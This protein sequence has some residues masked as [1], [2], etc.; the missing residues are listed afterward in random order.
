MPNLPW[1]YIALISG[2][3]GFT[4]GAPTLRL[5]HLNGMTTEAMIALRL[6]LAVLILTPFV[7]LRHRHELHSL[8][9]SDV[10][11]TAAAGAVL[12][13][14]LLL[15]VES[16]R[17]TTVVFNQVLVNTGPIWVALLEVLALRARF[18]K[19]V[20]LGLTV[21]I[22]GSSILLLYS[23]LQGTAIGG[24]DMLLGNVMALIS[25]MVGSVYVVLGRSIR[26]KVSFLPYIWLLFSAGGITAL[27]VV[28]LRG[29]PLTGYTSEAYFWV[30][31]VTI[32]PTFIG[33]AA[34]NYAL[35]GLSATLV[36]LS[37]QA[38]TLTTAVVAYLAFA[39]VPTLGTILGGAIIVLG[40]IITATAKQQTSPS[41][42]T[43]STLPTELQAEVIIPPRQR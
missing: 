29:L 13:L 21:A 9:R 30:V 32:F 23:A 2:I 40:V 10:G 39:E 22:S 3:V 12:T 43:R 24:P 25:A 27:V 19:Q 4:F 1:P 28:F 14:H 7:L 36:T 35:R 5:A 18:G 20:W 15:V 26:Q 8:T 38:S 16:L 37:G 33:H 41:S 11:L 17:Y 31:M 42:L 6:M 34:F